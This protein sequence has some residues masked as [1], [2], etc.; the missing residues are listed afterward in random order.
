MKIQMSKKS[1]NMKPNSL[2]RAVLLIAACITA[3]SSHALWDADLRMNEM[4]D[5]R[6]GFAAERGSPS[7]SFVA[8]QC[9]Q[10][11]EI[12]VLFTLPVSEKLRG[13][14]TYRVDSEKADTIPGFTTN[15][16]VGV[17]GSD[18]KKLIPKLLN[19]SELIAQGHQSGFGAQPT[20]VFKFG[21]AGSTKAFAAACSWHPDYE[22]LTS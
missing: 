7:G 22:G 18:A 8:I 2:K 13:R 12:I 4:T 17:L 21:L 3:P 19:G 14:V 10:G 1:D 20:R 15:G 6:I 9:Q 11:A 5:E 16:G